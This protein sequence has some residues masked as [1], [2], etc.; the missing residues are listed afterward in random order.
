MVLIC[1]GCNAHLF[2]G[3]FIFKKKNKYF[4]P[5]F[6]LSI[7]KNKLWLFFVFFLSPFFYNNAQDTTAQK[8]RIDFYELTL[9]QLSNIVITASKAPQSID[10]ITQKVDIVSEKE[11]LTTVLG[12]RNIAEL[13]QYLPG[14]S[15]KVLSRN[16][17]NW[18]SYGGIG[19]KYNTYMIQGLSID[20]FMDP[21]GIDVM[22]IQRIELQRGPASILYSNYLSQDFAGNQSPLAGT[23]NIIMKEDITKPVTALGLE[24]GSYN[25]YNVKLF[26]SN[27]FDNLHIYGGISYEKSDYVNYGTVNSWLN[28]QKNPEYQKTKTLFGTTYYLDTKENHKL[29][30]YGNQSFQLG[31][32]GRISRE[33]NFRYSL[34]NLTYSGKMTDYL[35]FVLKAGLRKYYRSWEE[36]ENIYDIMVMKETD[37]VEQT[38]LPFDASFSFSHLNNSLLTFGV[39]YQHAIYLTWIKSLENIKTTGNDALAKQLGIYFQEEFQL[40]NITLRGGGRFN[41]INYKINKFDSVS[42]DI[43]SKDWNVFLWSV[44]AKYHLLENFS[45]FTNAGSSFLTPGLKSIGGTLSSDDIYV[46]NKNGQL[47]N[48]DLKPENGYGFDFGIDYL[49]LNS[50]NLSLRAFSNTLNDAI[51]DIVIS[52][53]PSQT[54]SINASGNT[55]IKGI[56]FSVKQKIGKNVNWFGNGTYTDSKMKNSVNADQ[57]GIPIP[58]VPEFTGNLGLSLVLSYDIELSFMLHLGGIIYDSNSKT[59]RRSF[60]SKEL[61][62]VMVS[63]DI[64]FS[65]DNKINVFVKFYN[66]TNNH[67]EMPWQFKDAGFNITFGMNLLLNTI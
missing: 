55:T 8:N 11:I 32:F 30:F 25:T 17:V 35:K 45:L 41:I 46:L 15:V 40:D 12:N 58:F 1:N 42:P 36:D 22:G 65:S 6:N 37:G 54:K 59:N 4:F 5:N 13:I 56:E 27:R 57:D 50:I 51:I 3:D 2:M 61:L 60:N 33:F 20:G 18:G 67:F 23:V 52:E 7:I 26:H 47:P 44:G 10:K 63:K 9:E 19:P 48:H 62:N 16:D 39:D 29:T 43:N 64:S 28:M 66:I 38:I 24:Y 49:L 21:T 31:D 14:A 53:N 34:L